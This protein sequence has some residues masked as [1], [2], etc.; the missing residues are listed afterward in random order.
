M[1]VDTAHRED[2]TPERIRLRLENQAGTGYAGDFILGGIDGCVTTFAIVT[3]SVGAGFENWVVVVLGFA[4]LLADG[5][6]MAAGNYQN[7]KA[8][9]LRLKLAREE[10][11]RHIDL[12]PEGEEEEIRQIFIKKGFSGKLLDSVVAHVTSNKDLWV[13]TMLSDELGLPSRPPHAVKAAFVTYLAFVLI[14]G[15]PLI[16]Y[17]IPALSLH[18][19]FT[20]SIVAAC[21][22]F[23]AVGWLKGYMMGGR[24]W[25]AGIETLLTG[26]LA[27]AIA[28]LVAYT[29]RQAAGV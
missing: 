17:L 24:K 7:A 20:T 12:L 13:D 28:Y 21:F 25:T 3:A 5:F 26:G 8:Q 14:G 6:S 22:A 11:H 10:E 4:N 16:P 15:I 29:I 18:Q 27:A 1:N 23:F 9:G 2:H 19:A